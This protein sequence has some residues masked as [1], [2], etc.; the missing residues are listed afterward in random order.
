MVVRCRSCCFH[1]GEILRLEIALWI[2]DVGRTQTQ[3]QG[4][5]FA[6]PRPHLPEWG[7]HESGAVRVAPSIPPSHE[8]HCPRAMDLRKTVSSVLQ[9]WLKLQPLKRPNTVVAL[10]YFHSSF[11][12]CHRKYHWPVS[13]SWNTHILGHIFMFSIASVYMWASTCVYVCCPQP[14]SFWTI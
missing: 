2:F 8:P 6:S 5:G 4:C 12:T 14:D 3:T 1:L 7:H 10:R 11:C 13:A 9:P